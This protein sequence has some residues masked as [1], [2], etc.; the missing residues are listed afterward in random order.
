MPAIDGIAMISPE[1][2]RDCYENNTP[3]KYDGIDH[4]VMFLGQ[5]LDNGKPKRLGKQCPVVLVQRG[6]DCLALHVDTIIGSREMIT[7]SLG[8][9][10]AGL[11]GVNGATIL[12]DGRVVVIIDPMA[13]YR[14]QQ[15][16]VARAV[17]KPVEPV[18]P[19]RAIK[20]LV[21]DDS[22]TVRKVAS[23]LLNREG[24]EVDSAKDGVEAMIKLTE[25]KPDI[26]LLDIEMP[27]VDGFEVASSIRNNSLLQDLP[28][29][30]I[31]S[32]TGEKHRNRA[33]SLGVNE[34]IG[35]PFQEGPLLEAI[36]KLTIAV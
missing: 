10:F 17:P 24:Y 11:T 31:T 6:Q 4:K 9:Q 21:I 27:N 7:K 36:Q 16:Q 35:K 15:N 8:V 1:V 33:L 12:G 26:V 32:R 20:V 29:I 30:M 34:Y 5:L 2:M 3:L 13:L 25:E 19:N 18:N 28:I 22:V 14:R 23:R